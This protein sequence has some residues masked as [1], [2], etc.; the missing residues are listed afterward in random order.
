MQDTQAIQFSIF[1]VVVVVVVVVSLCVISEQKLKNVFICLLLQASV[2]KSQ[3][4]MI[5]LMPQFL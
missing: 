3:V 1:V 2:A 4:Y 5:L